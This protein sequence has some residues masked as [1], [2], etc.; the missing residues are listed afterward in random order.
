MTEPEITT[1]ELGRSQWMPKAVISSIRNGIP[2]RVSCEHAAGA[3]RWHAGL[4]V[5][6]DE[7]RH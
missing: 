1:P 2:E 5:R 3:G 7:H 4:P 6:R